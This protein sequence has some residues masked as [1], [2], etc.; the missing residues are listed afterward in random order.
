MGT[1]P[2]TVTERTERAAK[3]G[4]LT[5]SDLKITSWK[6][7][8]SRLSNVQSVKTISLDHNAL[9]K[10][11]PRSFMTL[12]LWK[13]LVSVD[14]SHNNITCACVLGS[15]GASHA[16]PDECAAASSATVSQTSEATSGLET[17]NLS[18]NAL[19]VLP[20]NLAARFPSLKRIVCKDNRRPLNGGSLA[21]C[22]RQS[23]SMESVNLSN[24]GLTSVV[25]L[26]DEKSMLPSMKELIL[27][28]NNFKG[29]FF[30]N[31]NTN[32]K[33]RISKSPTSGARRPQRHFE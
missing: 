15:G 20:A 25:L 11:I 5:L 23:K 3:T 13:T 19:S 9:S 28:S 24:S 27:S 2:S 12:Q 26:K 29:T 7:L 16:S 17:L 6:K 4:V 30:L 32:P 18:G 22:L 21:A 10:S 31:G 33:K 1:K 8:I 14:L